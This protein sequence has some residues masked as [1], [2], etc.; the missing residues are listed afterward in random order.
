MVR[1][2]CNQ[3]GQLAQ[4]FPFKVNSTDEATI[5]EFN[6]FFAPKSGGLWSFYD[7]LKSYV[8]KE[9]PHYKEVAGSPIRIN[10]RFLDFFDRMAAIT[11]AFYPNNSA[12]PNLA[13]S[14]TVEPNNVSKLILTISGVA[15]SQTGDS[16][17]FNWVGTPQDV[18]VT[19]GDQTFF[20]QSSTWAV[21]RFVQ[22][23]TEV[24]HSYTDLRWN[25]RINDN[26]VLVNGQQ[27]FYAYKLQTGSPNPF[28]LLLSPGPRCDP[29]VALTKP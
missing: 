17:N 15:L 28:E 18:K 25:L 3:F 12:T 9:G 16:K 27:A 13:Y 14:L 11:N 7:Q 1:T 4:I 23:G 29:R 26:P 5:E 6:A 21:A 19:A 24:R 10:P 22:S 2:L 8:T 20:N